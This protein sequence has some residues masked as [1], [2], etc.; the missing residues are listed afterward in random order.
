MDCWLRHWWVRMLV[1]RMRIFHISVRSASQEAFF[2][3]A[4]KI[5]Y[6]TF[7]VRSTMALG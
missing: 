2:A 6:C 4:R 3:M 7:T 5:I 1:V